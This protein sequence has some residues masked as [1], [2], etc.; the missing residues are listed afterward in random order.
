MDAIYIY[1][2]ILYILYV[3]KK[4]KYDFSDNRIFNVSVQN[5]VTQST[6]SMNGT[7]AVEA[8]TTSGKR[9]IC[10]NFINNE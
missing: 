2:Y 5:C 6:T 10:K 4:A 1:I 8:E 7:L 9:N 3:I